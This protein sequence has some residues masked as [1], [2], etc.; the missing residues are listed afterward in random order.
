MIQS[1]DIEP[2]VQTA[3]KVE[4]NSLLWSTL[5]PKLNMFNS[6]ATVESG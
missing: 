4:F 5:S 1:L 6:V 3:D 2:S